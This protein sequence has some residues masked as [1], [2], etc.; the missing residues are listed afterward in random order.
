MAVKRWLCVVENRVTAMSLVS[1]FLLE[2]CVNDSVASVPFC[3]FA[4]LDPRVGHNLNVNSPFI[5]VLCH[6]V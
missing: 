1:P 6:F 5:S 2:R 3:S 4:V